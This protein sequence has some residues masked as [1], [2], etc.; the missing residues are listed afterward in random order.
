MCRPTLFVFNS[1]AYGRT[2][3][4]HN[5]QTTCFRVHVPPQKMILSA[6]PIIPIIL[7]VRSFYTLYTG[8]ARPLTPSC[9]AA[10]ASQRKE[11]KSLVVCHTENGDAQKDAYAGC[12]LYRVIYSPGRSEDQRGKKKWSNFG[13]KSRRKVCHPQTSSV[14]LSA[15]HFITCIFTTLKPSLN[16]LFALQLSQEANNVHFFARLM[17]AKWDYLQ[18]TVIPNNRAVN[19]HR[20]VSDK[21]VY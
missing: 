10:A 12:C 19:T 16:S 6:W 14:I 13:D 1:D 18:I 21:W 7:S 3:S 5:S 17:P 2:P 11:G 4:A 20:K 9:D 15:R 8:T